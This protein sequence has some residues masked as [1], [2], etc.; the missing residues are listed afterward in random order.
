MIAAG[1]RPIEPFYERSHLLDPRVKKIQFGSPFLISLQVGREITD[2]V[3]AL[4]FL[5]YALKRAWGFDLELRIYREEMQ[6]RLLLAKERAAETR[7]HVDEA[8]R[9]A[10]VDD[11]QEEKQVIA[12]SRGWGAGAITSTEEIQGHFEG[13]QAVLWFDEE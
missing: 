4:A 10:Y 5:A 3:G 11:L 6:E 9:S 1:A 13:R 12:E 7:R 2:D 8:R